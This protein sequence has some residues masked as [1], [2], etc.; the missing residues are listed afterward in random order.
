RVPYGSGRQ[1]VARASLPHDA[2]GKGG[3]RRGPLWKRPTRKVFA[4][5]S[6][7][8]TGLSSFKRVSPQKI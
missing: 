2:R 6:T 3:M 7:R 8:L 5:M 1:P 4:S